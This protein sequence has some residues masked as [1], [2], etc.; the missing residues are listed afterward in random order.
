MGARSA[1]VKVNSDPDFRASFIKDPVG[2]LEREGVHLSAKDQKELL[3][4]INDIKKSISDLG[5]LPA[6]QQRVINA[7][8]RKVKKRMSGDPGPMII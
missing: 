5:E 4:T 2:T 1:F 7:V 3:D 6:G 8:D